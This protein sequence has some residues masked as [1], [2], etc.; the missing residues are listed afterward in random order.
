MNALAIAPKVAKCIRLLA[1]PED[2]EVLAAVSALQRTLKTADLDLNDLATAAEAGLTESRP[3]QPKAPEQPMTD[4]D[5][6]LWIRDVEAGSLSDSERDFIASCVRILAYGNYFS[7]KQRR[8]L[9]AI[10]LAM[11]GKHD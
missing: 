3:P 4:L 9:Q 11:G 2:G 1:S 10:Y 8:W 5:K 7:E 6:A